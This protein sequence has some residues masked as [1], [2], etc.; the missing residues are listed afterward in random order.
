MSEEETRTNEN[1]VVVDDKI[2]EQI[3]K[4][5]RDCDTDW[6]WVT[7]SQTKGMQR[8]LNTPSLMLWSLR[9]KQTQF[10]KIMD[11]NKKKKCNIQPFLYNIKFLNIME[12]T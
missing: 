11:Y 9:I 5:K 6:K 4:P 12:N 8:H 3:S 1:D 10:K 2:W 7:T